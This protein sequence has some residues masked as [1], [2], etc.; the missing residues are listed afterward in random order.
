LLLKIDVRRGDAVDGRSIPIVTRATKNV[1][2]LMV[3][4]TKNAHDEMARRRERVF[5]AE[6]PRLRERKRSTGLRRSPLVPAD[7]T[8]DLSRDVP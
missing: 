1:G 2:S 3:A 5:G 7:A 4:A 6:N 8:I